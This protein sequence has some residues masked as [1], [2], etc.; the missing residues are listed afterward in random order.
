MIYFIRKD[1]YK[2]KDNLKAVGCRWNGKYKCWVF[3]S[4]EATKGFKFEVVESL[5]KLEAPPDKKPFTASCITLN[6]VITNQQ[7]LRGCGKMEIHLFT[8]EGRGDCKGKVYYFSHSPFIYT[9][10][11]I[12]EDLPCKI[13]KS[14]GNF[15]FLDKILN[16]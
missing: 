14:Y 11:E 8:V 16:L 7:W 13:A 3:P 2:I 4:K 12:L 9:Q 15:I 1:T 6:G 10:G 5:N